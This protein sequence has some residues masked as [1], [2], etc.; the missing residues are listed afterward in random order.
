MIATVAERST[1]YVQCG[2]GLYPDCDQCGQCPGWHEIDCHRRPDTV[3]TSHGF[4]AGHGVLL[5][6]TVWRKEDHV[7][8]VRRILPGAPWNKSGQ[9]R[10]LSRG[11]RAP[12]SAA[13]P[14]S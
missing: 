13:T 14:P 9:S 12:S 2:C 10:N 5:G 4:P 1:A 6:H 8:Q 11:K 3:I 7:A